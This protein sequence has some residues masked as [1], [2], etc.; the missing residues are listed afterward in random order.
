MLFISHFAANRTTFSSISPCIQHQNALHLA[1]K[2]TAFSTKTHCIQRQNALFFAPKR[3]LFC[4]IQ[5]RNRCKQRPFLINIHCA[6]CT[7][8]PYFA[9]KPT[10]VRIVFSRQGWRLV[11]RNGTHNV[12][13][14]T[15]NKTKYDWTTCPRMAN[16]TY[17]MYA[18]DRQH[19]WLQGMLPTVNGDRIIET[20]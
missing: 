14:C 19:V 6:A 11:D 1:P 17:N 12:K 5:P 4:C 7:C 3:T 13:I 15:E 10:F 16:G 20:Q 9:S 2:R 8:H 18:Y